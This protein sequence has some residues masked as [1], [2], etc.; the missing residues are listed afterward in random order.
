M[1]EERHLMVCT[2]GNGAESLFECTV[3]GCGR[4]VVLDHVGT[5]LVVLH[6]GTG[7][8]LHQGTTGLVALSGS[9]QSSPRPAS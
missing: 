5:R 7:S 3:A 2:D 4:V 9:V 1:T 8:A 6:P